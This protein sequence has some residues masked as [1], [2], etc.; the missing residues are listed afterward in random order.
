VTLNLSREARARH[1]LR[2]RWRYAAGPRR[3]LRDERNADPFLFEVD[4]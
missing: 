3:T 1:D 4:A 2:L